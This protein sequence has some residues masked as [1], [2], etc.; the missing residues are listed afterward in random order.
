MVQIPLYMNLV[1]TART[2]ISAAASSHSSPVPLLLNHYH[3][4][5]LYSSGKTIF[6]KIKLVPTPPPPP[7]P[8]RAAAGIWFFLKV[9]PGLKLQVS[10]E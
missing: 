6:W 8:P 4:S 9:S 5:I 7:P 3:Q 10:S 1:V 2:G